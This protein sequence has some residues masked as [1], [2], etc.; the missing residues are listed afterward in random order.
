V[1]IKDRPHVSRA[2][3]LAAAA[4]K[5]ALADAA[6]DVSGMSREDLRGIGVIVG[7]GGGSQDFTE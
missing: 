1:E 7:S 6:I 3:P 5:E 4:V 2:V